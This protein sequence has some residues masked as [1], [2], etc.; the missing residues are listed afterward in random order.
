MQEAAEARSAMV[1]QVRVH[2]PE[3]CGTDAAFQRTTSGVVV[4]AV[5]VMW[6]RKL[7]SRAVWCTPTHAR[8]GKTNA[9]AVGFIL[10]VCTTHALPLHPAPACPA[11]PHP[12]AR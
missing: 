12:T 9:Q 10:S 4:V 6:G 1:P 8:P 3:C 2:V 11:P 7:C 5:V